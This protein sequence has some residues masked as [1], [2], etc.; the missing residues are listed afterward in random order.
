M[1]LLFTLAVFLSAALLFTVQ[2]MVAKMLLPQVG[3]SPAVWNACMVFFQLALLAGYLYA[4]ALTRRLSTTA[5]L[6]VH[7]L[8]LLAPLVLLPID[9]TAR[10]GPPRG[11]SPVAWILLTL[12]VG[13]GLPFFVVSTTG[14][15]LQRWFSRTPHPAAADPY[16]LYAA[17]NAGSLGGLLLYPV[18]LEPYLRLTARASFVSQTTLWAVGYVGFVLLAAAC[19]AWARRAE[20]PPTPGAAP[21][22]PPPVPVR[23]RLLW[24]GLAFVPSSALLGTT[25]YITQD[26]AAF[27]LLWTLPLAIYLASF[28]LVFSKRFPQRPQLWGALLGILVAGIGASFLGLVR[29]RGFLLVPLHLLALF[30]VAM[31]AHGRLASLRPHVG[32]LTEFYLCL[33]LGGALGGIFNALVAPVL[34]ESTLEYPLIL[35]LACLSRARWR[36][37]V[38][39]MRTRLA[40]LS[41]LGIPAAIGAATWLLAGLSV[42][43][44]S[45]G[46][47]WLPTVQ[48]GVPALLCL[49]TLGWRLRFALSVGVLLGYGFW[50][51]SDPAAALARERT[52][53]GIHR[54]AEVPGPTVEVADGRGGT[55]EI[56][57]LFHVLIHGATR[58]GSQAM[59]PARRGSPTS[60][61]HRSG[62][63]GQV[64]E[65]MSAARRLREVGLIGLGA[66]TLAAYGEPGARFTY[67]EIDPAVVRIA[68]DRELFT[69]LSDTRAD[70]RVV[71]GDGR[72]KLEQEPD[73]HFDLLVL[74]AFSSDAIPVH[75]LTREAIALYRRKLAPDGVIALHLTNQF[76]TLSPVVAAIS[77][78]LGN[79]AFVR[80]DRVASPLEAFEGKD[81][82][83]WAVLAEPGSPLGGLASD[84]RWSRP[85][86]DARFLWTDDYSNVLG[87]IR[88]R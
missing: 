56:A 26:I 76:M 31:V 80:A 63:I 1:A 86:A 55:T 29:S 24:I 72:L 9:L 41:D 88:W 27:P 7:G 6:A 79:P 48:A 66:G 25:Q 83:I 10:G 43:P 28:M 22:P 3:G 4:H 38:A 11:A 70:L 58:H 14:P 84:A 42:E 35:F 2:P 78:D 71:T 68:S 32:R 75:L 45:P 53:F 33:A 49:A 30:A 12:A 59:D 18:V 13:A 85:A 37:E 77:A 40:W 15:L 52:F 67:F 54:V 57:Q 8:L 5:Q 20:S 47:S 82:S 81:D 44:G 64:F 62:P 16:F 50:S 39:S 73:G 87:V 19:A 51:I 34:F 36:E 74:D 46:A 21:E 65:A 17:S 23:D 60:Y 61:F 69:Y